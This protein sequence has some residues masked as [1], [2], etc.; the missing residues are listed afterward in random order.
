MG[1]LLISICLTMFASSLVAVAYTFT[2]TFA[3]LTAVKLHVCVGDEFFVRLWVVVVVLCIVTQGA[4]DLASRSDVISAC[5]SMI[6]STSALSFMI[7]SVFA[8]AGVLHSVV[9]RSFQWQAATGCVFMASTLG[10]AAVVSQLHYGDSAT[11]TAH[12]LSLFVEPFG[13]GFVLAAMG[14]HATGLTPH[15]CGKCVHR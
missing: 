13:T 14:H 10:G 12:Y 7:K 11:L 8:A 1:M 15:S 3:V 9:P 2:A 5:I 6:N 4:M